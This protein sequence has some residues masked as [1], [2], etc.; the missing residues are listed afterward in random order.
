M[1]YEYLKFIDNRYKEQEMSE[2]PDHKKKRRERKFGRE[3]RSGGFQCIHCKSPV[4]LEASGTRHRNHCP[5]CLWSR[6]VDDRKG[7][8]A[9]RCG[10]SM[11]PIGLTFKKEGIDKYKKTPK[12]GEAML[13]HQCVRC[14]RISINR[15]AGDDNSAAVMRIFYHSLDMP[16]YL[17]EKLL[18]Q[19]IIPLSEK[20]RAELQKQLGIR[21]FKCGEY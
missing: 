20:D 1:Y 4:S 18:K 6:H 15:L 12:Q 7:D 16:A 8:R 17:R 14:G 13:I 10:T 3:E 11:I 21:N 9:A 5:V 2:E 19:N